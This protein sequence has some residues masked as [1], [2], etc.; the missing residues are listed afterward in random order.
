MEMRAQQAKVLGLLGGDADPVAVE[1]FGQTGES[2]HRVERQIDGVELDVGNGVQQR[3]VAL[4]VA[5]VAS[6]HLLRGDQFGPGG[7]AGQGGVPLGPQGSTRV[8]QR[9]T[10]SEIFTQRKGQLNL[11]ARIGLDQ[12]GERLRT[13]ALG[14]IAPAHCVF[15]ST[16]MAEAI[17]PAA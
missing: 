11:G 13:R 5:R 10:G 6:G 12:G 9:P 16:V 8:D 17:S 3:G 1:I 15:F 7:A 2:P 14:C 4:R